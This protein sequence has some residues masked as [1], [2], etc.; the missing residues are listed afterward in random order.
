VALLNLTVLATQLSTLL[1]A[2]Y[3]NPDTATPPVLAAL[4]G[5]RSYSHPVT[6][7]NYHYYEAWWLNTVTR[8]LPAHWQIWEALPFAIAFVGIALMAWTAWRVLGTSAAVLTTVLMLALGD[9]MRWMLFTAST[10][11]FVVAHAALLMAVGVFIAKRGERGALS[12]SL[13]AGAGVPLVALSAAGATDQLFEI[14][15]LPSFALAGCLAYW[16]SP[17]G[18]AWKIA[19]FC[20]TVS[21]ASII[22]GELLNGLMRSQNL[23]YAPL[24]ISFV[25]P[26]A[27][28]SNI[29]L[30][31]VSLAA[32][33]GG[34]FFNVPVKGTELLVFAAGMIALVGIGVVLRLISQH[35][36]LLDKRV[37]LGLTRELYV[38]FWALVVVL[39]LAAYLLSN[40]PVA[41]GDVRYLPGVYAGV[42]ALM[43][44]LAGRLAARRAILTAS[45]A[46]FA[47][48]I[49]VNHLIE[50]PIG[51]GTGVEPGV[52]T[53]DVAYQMLHFVEAEHASHGYAPYYVAPVVTWETRAKLKT[54]PI[55]PCGSG[56]CPFPFNQS[57]NWYQAQPGVRSF[58]IS[59]SV[60]LPG[61]VTSAP[62][63][64]GPPAATATFGEYTV[65]VYNQDIAA[66]LF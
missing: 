26:Q 46:V 2:L 30:T 53:S 58:L 61:T 5:P 48:L 11:G 29:Q 59:D 12:W 32:L 50:G 40:L 23:T 56:L 35:A 1:S 3:S 64:F 65:Y 36:K 44:L 17:G 33:G 24:A 43:P 16:R 60:A 51:I 39:S 6:L 38:S 28:L 19:I 63:A 62:S 25:G 10:H 41:E 49:A 9:A 57:A 55:Q 37:G 22:G 4:A 45:V 52:P 47:V 18:A 14:V 21:I 54:Y 20:V 66:E 31:I 42:A 34:S 13:L 8:G 27:I 7:G 15:F